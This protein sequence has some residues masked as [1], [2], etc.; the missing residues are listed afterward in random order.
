[1]EKFKAS[2]FVTIPAVIFLVVAAALFLL[3][4]PLPKSAVPHSMQITVP[5]DSQPETPEPTVPRISFLDSLLQLPDSLNVFVKPINQMERTERVKAVEQCGSCHKQ[6]YKNW[7]DGPHANAYKSMR[8]LYET[9]IDSVQ[10]YFPKGYGKWLQKSLVVCYQCHATE[11]LFETNF[12]GVELVQD[13]RLIND[14]LFPELHGYAR[15][16]TDPKTFSTG[17]DC[18]TCHYNGERVITGPD[19]KPD[20]KKAA[21]PGYCNPLPTPFFTTN[22]NCY[23]CHHFSDQTLE[24]NLEKGME[25]KETNCIRCHQTYDDK[26]KGTHY[27]EWRFADHKKHPV[28]HPKGGLFE[29][30]QIKVTP[31]EPSRL[32]FDWANKVAPHALSECGEVVLEILV[33]DQSGRQ[34]LKKDVRLNRKMAHDTILV[35]QLEGEGAPGIA[36]YSFDASDPP[37]R[38]EFVLEGK[39]IRSGKIYL[40]AIDKAQYWADDRVGVRVFKKT[41]S[42]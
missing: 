10:G 7:S 36:G 23:T 8:S 33:K 20:P 24:A 9:A 5:Q 40:T 26:G 21:M 39:G 16:R 14:S 31:G 28:A 19:F 27:Y 6:E 22:T 2:A 35:T 4:K 3:R 29:A 32:T 12:K 17:V 30:I 37:I 41:I 34:V 25:F 11:N 42:F 1:M 38:E 13:P 18:F 15:P